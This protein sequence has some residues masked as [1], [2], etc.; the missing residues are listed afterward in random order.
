MIGGR[1]SRP[2]VSAAVGPAQGRT[3]G[4]SR[5]VRP[6][7]R[8]ADRPAERAGARPV[9]GDGAQSGADDLHGDAELYSGRGPGRDHRSRAGGA[10]LP[11][12]WP[13]RSSRARRWRRSW[14][15][16][17]IAIITVPPR[18]GGGG[19][20]CWRMAI[21]SGARSPLMARLA[22]SGGSGGGEGS[23]RACS[24]PAARRGE[25]VGA[26]ADADGA[27]DAGA[28]VGPSEL[29]L[30]GGGGGLYRRHGDGLGE[31]GDL[32][33]RRG[34]RCFRDSPVRVDAGRPG[35]LS[36]AWRAGR[37]EPARL[38][39][40]PRASGRA[41]G[42]DPGRARTGPATPDALL[43]RSGVGIDPAR[44]AA[45]RNVLAHL[46]DLAERGLVEA[47]ERVRRHR[48]ALDCAGTVAPGADLFG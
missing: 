19:R 41:R 20:R 4:R 14:S 35:L 30:A 31:P 26:P 25:M 42:A 24:G 37:T 10:A 6:Q 47:G 18:W 23:M 48:P 12:G 16:T 43:R 7:P 9:G 44:P 21:R 17:P 15:P 33:A 3:D 46:I 45:A 39:D 28:S 13:R 8:P 27:G 29:C 40:W 22:A 5:S 34:C 36:R 38:V 11:R 2:R 32:A 1:S